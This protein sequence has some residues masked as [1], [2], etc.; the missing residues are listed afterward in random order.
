[1]LIATTGAASLGIANGTVHGSAASTPAAL[2][3]KVNNQTVTL[4]SG[5]SYTGTQIASAIQTQVG[6]SAG[7]TASYASGKLVVTSTG[8]AGASDAVTVNTFSSGT[9]HP[10]RLHRS[11]RD[12]QRRRGRGAR[13][14]D[15]QGQ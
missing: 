13:Q 5:S 15:L 4:A 8:T 6:T 2:T 11:D 7:V 12:R 3:F 14:P 10:A 1:M 9:R